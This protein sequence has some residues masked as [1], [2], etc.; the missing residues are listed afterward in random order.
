MI[1]LVVVLAA[2]ASAPASSAT[3]SPSA[4]GVPPTA[5]A[6]AIV[7]VTIPSEGATPE[8]NAHDNLEATT[9]QDKDV[10][11]GDLLNVNRFELPFTAQIMDYLPYIDIKNMAITSDA[12]SITPK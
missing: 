1:L 5:P 8:A 3:Q 12:I 10:K 2:C 7:H 9:F 11:T 6:A 4:T